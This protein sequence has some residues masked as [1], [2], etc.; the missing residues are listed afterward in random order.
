MQHSTPLNSLVLLYHRMGSPFVRS[1]V[2]GQYVFPRVFRWQLQAFLGRQYRAVRLAELLQDAEARCGQFAVTFD[3]GFTSMARLACPILLEMHIPATLYIVVGGIGKTNVWDQREGDRAETMCTAAEVRELAELGFEIGSHSM[4]HPRLT[5]L[6]DAEVR[7]E[8]VDSKQALED[9][10]GRAVHSFSYPYGDQ[11][12]R[13]RRM[14]AEAGYASRDGDHVVHRFCDHG[15]AG[16]TPREYALEHHRPGIGAEIAP[17]H[18][19]RQGGRPCGFWKL[20]RRQK[21]EERKSTWSRL[22]R[23]CVGI[24]T[25]LRYFVPAGARSSVI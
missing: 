13:V 3:D 11:D 24:R 6:S 15:C 22:C 23:R 2:R 20:S 18:S 8:I 14:V 25:R 5:R 21:S 16:D 19:R 10:L 9:L 1:I 17:C 4:T 12:A 7:S